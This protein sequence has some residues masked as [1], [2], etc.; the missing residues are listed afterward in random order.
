MGHPST[1]GISS[2]RERRSQRLRGDLHR[3]EPVV[4][5][6]ARSI[7]WEDNDAEQHAGAPKRRR[8]ELAQG[9][10]AAARKGCDMTRDVQGARDRYSFSAS[11]K[12]LATAKKTKIGITSCPRLPFAS[13]PCIAANLPGRPLVARLP[14][15]AARP[16]FHDFVPANLTPGERS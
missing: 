16:P 9:R 11:R 13:P 6:R 1:A 7:E 2:R 15:P 12:R 8:R 10:P 14:P 5:R 4:F 3:A